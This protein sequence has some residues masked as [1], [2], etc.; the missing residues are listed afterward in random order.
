MLY[1]RNT[2]GWDTSVPDNYCGVKVR[3]LKS[4][5]RA[6]LNQVFGWMFAL[7]I[8]NLDYLQYP[9]NQE[10]RPDGTPNPL[11]IPGYKK[12]NPSPPP[13]LKKRSWGP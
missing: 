9:P 13:P 6:F 8:P 3:K 7:K 5:I 1:G 2:A 4:M 12:P 10:F 11:Y